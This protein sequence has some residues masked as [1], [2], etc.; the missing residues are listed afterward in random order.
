MSS[1]ASK[2]HALQRRSGL[3]F[4]LDAELKIWV[5][6]CSAPRQKQFDKKLSI[7]EVQAVLAR[8]VLG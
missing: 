2:H 6:R 3:H 1:S 4:E 5:P 8:Y 7:Y